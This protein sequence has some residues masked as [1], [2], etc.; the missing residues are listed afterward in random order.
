[1]A[2]PTPPEGFVPASTVA[3]QPPEGF[4]PV[5]QPGMMES[6]LRGAAEGATF[7][8]DDKLGL[9]KNAR[10]ASRAAN[11]WTHLAG[12]L[13]GGFAPMAVA[14]PIGAAARGAGY[15]ARGARAASA[16][17]APGEMNTIGQGIAQGAKLGAVY[18]GLS[19][20]GH[21][22]V[23]PNSSLPE[24][25]WERA[26]GAAKGSAAGTVMGAVAGVPAYAVSRLAQGLGGARAA[27]RAETED[28]N[29]GALTA[30]ARGFQRD[31]VTPDELIGQ[32]RAEFPSDTAT[33]GGAGV[34]F[35]G[36]GNVPAAQRGVWTQDMV[37]DVV[38][39]AM[40]G[41]D[42][43]AISQALSPNGTGPGAGSVQTLLDELAQRHLGPLNI[44]DRAALVRPGSGSNTQMTLRAA[45]ATPGEA[46]GLAREALLERQ[47]GA[48]GRLGQIF[49]RVIGD[50][51]Y[52]GVA[53][54][55]ATD[56]ENAG[57]R[58]Y[59]QA[60]ANEQPFDLTPIFGRYQA[61]YGNMAGPIPRG[62]SNAMDGMLVEQT[63]AN[64]QRVQ[65]P[66]NSLESFIMARQG[67]NDAISTAQREGKDNLARR[68]TELHRDLTSEVAR[69][70]P[71][72]L[73]AN[74]IWRD[75]RA[76]QEALEAG[77]RMS[78]RLSARSRETLSEF[79]DARNLAAQGTRDLRRAT[80]ANDQAAIDAAQARIDAGNSRMELFRVGLV[81]SLNDMIANKSETSNL[82]REMLLPGARNMLTEVLG[83]E[84]SGQLFRALQ[85]ENSMNRTYASQFGSQTTPLRE[86]ID[87]LNWA[88]RF[89]AH[90][91]NPMS[92]VGKLGDL[93]VERLAHTINA[94]RNAQLMRHM[95]DTDP[96]RQLELLRAV[97]G[98]HA[99]RSQAGRLAATPTLGSAAA[100]SEA[101][102][103]PPAR[104]VAPIAP[105]DPR[106]GMVPPYRP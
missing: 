48:G 89:E 11:P 54:R 51:D 61:R 22:E 106:T 27:A 97:R 62:V 36:P 87:D 60:F 2:A 18:G 28:A 95:T 55:H 65:V 96:L 66:P 53:A 67:L 34:R 37:E 6:F 93:A 30:L 72:W 46:Q 47:I 25:T 57:G 38:R 73:E 58:A 104:Q 69:T 16:L 76:A 79:T 64:G 17:L 5:Q 20:A 105:Y 21:A 84:R 13:V 86:A 88:P 101:A 77:S 10:E 94:T 14:G 42:A 7:G 52:A 43:N 4:V 45:A 35:W 103:A 59:S 39:R 70:N 41:E 80:R 8:F 29:A 40:N 71:M 68:L 56:L 63:L 26:K 49:D 85:A 1:M 33:A 15:L 19:G 83:N 100:L 50:S 75:G 31:R 98:V 91:Y 9:D 102:A 81:R 32:I 92:W 90:W 12:E 74:N 78:T 44:V 3:P 82:T 99:A 24:S 23:D